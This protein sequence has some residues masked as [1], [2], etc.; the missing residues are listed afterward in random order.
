MNALGNAGLREGCLE[1]K[2]GEKCV[3]KLWDGSIAYLHVYIKTEMIDRKTKLR[4]VTCVREM[5]LVLRLRRVMWILLENR[6]SVIFEIAGGGRD[7]AQTD[8]QTGRYGVK[9]ETISIRMRVL[10]ICA[11]ERVR[12]GY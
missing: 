1:A 2:Q 7:G 12:Q 3:L 10:L 8:R 4:R 6:I 5:Q 9:S 11:W